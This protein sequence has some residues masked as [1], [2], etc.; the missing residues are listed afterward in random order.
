MIFK[1]IPILF[2]NKIVVTITYSNF[3]LSFPLFPFL[4]LSL[5]KF[6]ERERERKRG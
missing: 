4:S 2:E 5:I 1:K 3:F 6:G